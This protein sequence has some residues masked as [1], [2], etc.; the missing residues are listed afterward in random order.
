MYSKTSKTAIQSLQVLRP[1]TVLALENVSFI[2]RA[3]AL[4]GVEEASNH[5]GEVLLTGDNPDEESID[6]GRAM[7]LTPDIE[8]RMVVTDR[9]VVVGGL[10]YDRDAENPCEP[11]GANGSIYHGSTRRGD[12]DER[13]NYYAALG[14]NADG[15]KDYSSKSVRDRLVKRA[16]KGIGHDLSLLT[17]LL[18]R[19]RATGRTVSKASL[20]NVIQFAID[21]EG[22][23]YAPDYVA[24]ALYGVPYWNRIEGKLL[25]DLEPL[26]EL[27]SESVAEQCWDE[28][29]EAGDVGNP[30]AVPLDIYEHGGVSYSLAGTGMNCRWD[31]S[32]AAAVWVPDEDAIS[33]IRA[34]VMS[35]LGIGEPPAGSTPIDAR[36]LSAKM[37]EKA[38]EYCKGILEEYNDWANGSVYGVVVYVIDRQTGRRIKAHDDECWGFIGSTYAESELE[39]AILAKVVELG[40]PLH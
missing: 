17:R 13:R 40:Q 34:S 7:R 33:N 27:L 15:G 11:G 25:E 19:L 18:H 3:H 39:E 1:E 26:A 38:R 31:T 32:H 22:W 12:A 28:A 37:Y 35:E 5:L 6:A 14:L 8:Q 20:Q 10:V 21:Q 24:D 29:Q 9:H 2:L 16:M 30:L 4:P 36:I 23:E